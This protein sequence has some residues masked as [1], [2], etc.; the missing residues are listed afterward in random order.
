M[1]I[2]RR[3]YNEE[4]STQYVNLLDDER[5]RRAFVEHAVHVAKTYNFDGIDLAWEFP[6]YKKN[7]IMSKKIV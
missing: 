2:G 7:P 4:R 1:S 6:R 5:S 3:E